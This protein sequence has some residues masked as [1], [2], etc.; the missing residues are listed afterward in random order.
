MNKY[1]E[2]LKF[3]S[4]LKS[5]EQNQIGSEIYTSIELYRGL[6]NV[7]KEQKDLEFYNKNYPTFK[8]F[9]KTFERFIED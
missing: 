3:Y 5:S 7:V 2:N 4:N 9:E 1:K 8:T 6:L